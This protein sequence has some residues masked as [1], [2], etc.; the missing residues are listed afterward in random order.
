MT[1]DIDKLLRLLDEP[2]TYKDGAFDKLYSFVCELI[3]IIRYFYINT[4]L[5]MKLLI[6][7][8]VLYFGVPVYAAYAI[9]V[10]WTKLID[11][12]FKYNFSDEDFSI[13]KYLRTN[14]IRQILFLLVGIFMYFYYQKTL[15]W[16]CF[17][18]SIPM[19]LIA[20]G[21]IAPGF[22]RRIYKEP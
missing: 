19:T 17:I 5:F 21:Y 22:D 18:Y 12:W 3:L 15:G 8:P 20:A 1:V 10:I 13:R 16:L 4:N 14:I 6:G 2:F 7:L 9:F 11:I